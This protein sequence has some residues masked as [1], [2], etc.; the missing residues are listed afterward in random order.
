MQ[1]WKVFFAGVKNNQKLHEL[2]RNPISVGLEKNKLFHGVYEVYLEEILTQHPIQLSLNPED[3][4]KIIHKLIHCHATGCTHPW[5][6][7]VRGLMSH[8]RKHTQSKSS[9]IQHKGRAVTVW[10]LVSFNSNLKLPKNF[11]IL[12]KSWGQGG[13]PGPAGPHWICQCRDVFFVSTIKLTV[14]HW[15]P[16]PVIHSMEGLLQTTGMVFHPWGSSI[17]EGLPQQRRP[18]AHNPEG[19]LK[20]RGQTDTTQGLVSST[21]R[22]L[23][24]KSRGGTELMVHVCHKSLIGGSFLP[25]I[26][27]AAFSPIITEVAMVFPVVISGIMLASATLSPSMPCT[28]L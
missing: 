16:D 4:M 12:K 18:H 3:L 15:A 17:Q 26:M 13:G 20:L 5:W 11:M 21:G 23:C 27:S 8:L 7:F 6:I 28:L 25:R 2:P 1:E 9:L 19:R 10:H 24:R 14:Q 22:P